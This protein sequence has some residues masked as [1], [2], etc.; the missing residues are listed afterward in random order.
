MRH[1][2]EGRQRS[3]ERP[4]SKAAELRPTKDESNGQEG[5]AEI[6]RYS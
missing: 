2:P 3:E 4:T 6:E 1:L 5:E